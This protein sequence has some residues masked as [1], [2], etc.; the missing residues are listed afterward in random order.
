MKNRII[1]LPCWQRINN[2]LLIPAFMTYCDLL[3]NTSGLTHLSTSEALYS[4]QLSI[5]KFSFIVLSTKKSTFQ[6]PSNSVNGFPHPSPRF[7]CF[8][9]S[10]QYHLTSGSTSSYSSSK[11]RKA[12]SAINSYEPKLFY[13]IFFLKSK[14]LKI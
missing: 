3:A 2:K 6:F 14:I 13:L 9:T 5:F 7:C 11:K 10:L 4:C 12:M 1:I 8:T